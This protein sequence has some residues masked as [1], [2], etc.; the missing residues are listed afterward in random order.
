MAWRISHRMAT[1]RQML[2]PTA[3][4]EIYERHAAEVFAAALGILR[5]A[6]VA[7]DVVQD[8]FERLWVGFGF[9]ERRGELAPYLRL[10]ARSRALDL[11]RR[12]RTEE[13]AQHR[14]EVAARLPAPGC[15]TPEA[16]LV[17]SMDE[18]LA[19]AA[20]RRLPEDQRRAIGLAYWG[21]LTIPEV[22]TAEGIPLGT[23]KSRVRIGLGKLSRDRDLAR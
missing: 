4:D 7:E 11:W 12:T 5:D 16:T 8:V 15:G 23:A 6:T 20:V 10:M 3:F 19:R 22:A 13:R 2:S 9:D 1:L 21:G 17:Q 14:L 18:Q